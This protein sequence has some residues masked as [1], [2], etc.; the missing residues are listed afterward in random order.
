MDFLR[1]RFIYDGIHKKFSS[2]STVMELL[3]KFKEVENEVVTMLSK[4][5]ALRA[6]FGTVVAELGGKGVM[7]LDFFEED[8]EVLFDELMR[9]DFSGRPKKKA[10]FM[11]KYIEP[12]SI[13]KK[14]K[15]TIDLDFTYYAAY[16]IVTNVKCQEKLE[17]LIQKKEKYWEYWD[18]SDYKD[19]HLE[20]EVP[21]DLVWNY[22]LLIGMIEKLRKEEYRGE[23]YQ[24]FYKILYAGNRYWKRQLKKNESLT[25]DDIQGLMLADMK[26][27]NNLL[28]IQC[29]SML[30]FL[31]ANDMELPIIWDGKMVAVLDMFDEFETECAKELKENDES[32]EED[33]EY[34]EEDEIQFGEYADEE[35]F[36]KAFDEK[37]KQHDS[38][39]DILMSCVDAEEIHPIFWA[40]NIFMIGL[41]KYEFFKL[42]QTEIE[43]L[44][45]V[46]KCW[47]HTKYIYLLVIAVLSKYVAYLETIYIEESKDAIKW[48]SRQK[49]QI[50]EQKEQQDLQY[51]NEW[52]RALSEKK[53]LEDTLLNQELQIAKLKK[54]LE[55]SETQLQEYTQELSALRSYVYL[56]NDEHEDD[57]GKS[58]TASFNMNKVVE[59][60]KERKVLVLGGHSNWQGKL[61]EMFPKWQFLSARQSA[62][63]GNVIAGKEII[64]CNTG[65]LDHPSYYK[66]ISLKGKQQKLCYVHSNN[67]GKCLAELEAQLN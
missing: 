12:M 64:L 54:Q 34:T 10:K 45:T 32:L 6:R 5:P 62:Q 43:E 25:S 16:G 28:Q 35:A 40:M 50:E 17:E 65:F 21:A 66:M 2:K 63:I 57:E 29:Q 11:E 30:L 67:M 60:W 13:L 33:N 51:E 48:K 52:K 15:Q 1:G 53:Q 56:I 61:K 39:P 47:N 44:I 27:H 36:F 37:Y 9:W 31:M 49:Q 55:T 7:R 22:R 59:A 20:V 23:T 41:R 46:S 8:L 19:G 4:S 14:N 26:E 58:S 24:L 38:L 3:M 18:K 42:T